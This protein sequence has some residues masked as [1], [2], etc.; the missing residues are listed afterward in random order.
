MI[1]SCYVT[2]DEGGNYVTWHELNVFVKIKKIT[3]AQSVSLRVA[4]PYSQGKTGGR[5]GG[6]GTATR[7]LAVSVSKREF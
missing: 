2:V 5:E 7:R 3:N 1:V 6:E 4:A